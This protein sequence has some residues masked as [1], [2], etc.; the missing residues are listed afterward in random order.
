MG[1]YAEDELA[2]ADWEDA[3]EQLAEAIRKDRRQKPFTCPVCSGVHTG[4][5]SGHCKTKADED[6]KSLRAREGE[7]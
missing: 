3:H 6:R 1:E 7:G 4:C 5:Y 2:T